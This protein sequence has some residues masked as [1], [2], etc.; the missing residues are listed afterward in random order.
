MSGRLLK[1]VEKEVHVKVRRSDFVNSFAGLPS[2]SITVHD[3]NNILVQG[4]SELNNEEVIIS[5]TKVKDNDYEDTFSSGLYIDD[6]SGSDTLGT[7]SAVDTKEIKLV[8]GKYT[9]SITYLDNNGIV[10]EEAKKKIKYKDYSDP[11]T[12]FGLRDK[13]ETITLPRIELKPAPLGG[14]LLDE[15][16]GYWDVSIDDLS[17]DVVTMYVIRQP[18]PKVHEELKDIG[19]VRLISDKYAS[20]IEPQWS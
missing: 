12:G 16:N 2:G 3:L 4:E 7:N 10:I 15:Q 19:N 9:L 17:K 5:L 1:I 18:D 6:N 14:A 11:S 13:E 8:P 20:L